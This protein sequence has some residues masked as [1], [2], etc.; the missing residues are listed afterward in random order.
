MRGF[1]P[2]IF[3]ANKAIACF[4]KGILTSYAQARAVAHI[5]GR[6]WDQ[7]A[8]MLQPSTLERVLGEEGVSQSWSVVF[9][10]LKEKSHHRTGSAWVPLLRLPF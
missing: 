10:V 3:D 1:S 5:E 6:A 7:V 9:R 8:K 2:R 4:P